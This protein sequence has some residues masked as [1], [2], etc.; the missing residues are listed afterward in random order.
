MVAT[1]IQRQHQE[2]GIAIDTWK[3][4]WNTATFG[5]S[6]EYMVARET[7]PSEA[8]RMLETSGTELVRL[9]ENVWRTQARALETAPF[10]REK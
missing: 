6:E 5:T 9:G 8:K 2:V 10:I 3:K 1:N 7:E 4:V